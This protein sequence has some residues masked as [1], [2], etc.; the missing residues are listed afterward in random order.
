M[1]LRVE[2][3]VAEELLADDDSQFK[4]GG[5][6]VRT[7]DLA[8]LA[9]FDRVELEFV[10]DFAGSLVISGQVVQMVPG[11][12]VAVTFERDR[13]VTLLDAARG[14]TSP[15]RAQGRPGSAPPNDQAARI[16]SALYGGRDERWRVIR[17]VNKMLHP[18]V[19]RNAGLGLDEVLAIAKLSTVAPDLLAAI[20]ERREWAQRPDIATALVR[21][22]KTPTA[23]AVRLLDHV[24]AQELRQLAK[25]SRTRPAIQQAARK[26]VIG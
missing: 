4:R 19:L 13:L 9:L 22:P 6:L 10:T 7:A 17:D 2:Y 3:R 20:A 25:D 23:A 16:H 21:N 26:K 11:T 8:G 15:P 24:P 14:A 5:L 12:G 18:Y 1:R